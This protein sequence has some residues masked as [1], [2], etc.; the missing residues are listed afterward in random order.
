MA[1]RT[2]FPKRSW[3]NAYKRR[4]D[5]ADSY[6]VDI[7]DRPD[8]INCDIR[9]LAM[10]FGT[11]D[12]AW[13]NFLIDTRDIMMRPFGMK[14]TSDLIASAAKTPTLEKGPG[15]RIGFFKIYEIFENE[16][17]LGEDD[18]HQDFRVSI[19]RENTSTSKV[20]MTTVCQRHN[21]FGKAYLLAILPFHKQIVKS[22]L[23]V[24]AEKP[25]AA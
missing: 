5:F 23:K 16:I 24:G 17:I 18:W 12:I 11:V 4:Q 14:A 15:D 22:T 1:K 8:L 2:A 10:Q 7:S 19:F 3:L 6:E 25:M 9:E 20:I 21:I 13:A